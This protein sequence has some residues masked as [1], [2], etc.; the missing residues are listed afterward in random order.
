MFDLTNYREQVLIRFERRVRSFLGYFLF[1]FDFC[2]ADM[3]SIFGWG[4][5]VAA[6]HAQA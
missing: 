3:R 6:K 4:K 2:M 1:I 5:C